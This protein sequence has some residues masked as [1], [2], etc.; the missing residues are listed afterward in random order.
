MKIKHLRTIGDGFC[1]NHYWPMWSQLLAEILDCEW[2]NFSLPGLGNEAIAN[3]VLDQVS[4]EDLPNTLWVI[5]WAEPK[6]LDFRVDTINPAFLKETESDPIYYKNFIT[7]AQQ[8]K[9]WSSSASIL[10]WV[11]EQ[12]NLITLEQ[13]QDRQKLFELAVT[14]A[15]EKADVQWQYI[16]TPGM[17]SFL[18]QSKYFDLDV[19]EIQPVSSVHLDFLEQFVLP[20]LDIDTYRLDNIREKTLLIDQE[21]KHSNQFVP[22]DRNMY[23]RV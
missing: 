19:G 12:R 23:K 1:F 18:K 22:W 11:I 14:H 20:R 7:T 5:Q 3:I 10:P 16:S 21:R 15:L 4:A 17:M 2:Q 6:R 8:R 13:Y 9:Y